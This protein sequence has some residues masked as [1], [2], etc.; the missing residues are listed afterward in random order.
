MRESR[1]ARVGGIE[2]KKEEEEE[3]GSS[4]CFKSGVEREEDE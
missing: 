4:S 2:R 1:I 3:E